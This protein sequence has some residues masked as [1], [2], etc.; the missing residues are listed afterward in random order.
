MSL[1]ILLVLVFHHQN[2]ETTWNSNHEVAGGEIS[3]AYFNGTS[4]ILVLK[5]QDLKD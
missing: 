2:I 1:I 3:N 4:D 5:L